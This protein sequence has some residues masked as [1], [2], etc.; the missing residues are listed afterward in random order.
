MNIFDS[1]K[2]VGG[3][4]VERVVDPE[5][6]LAMFGEERP[7][8]LPGQRR[9]TARR[10]AHKI[11][12]AFTF[13]FVGLSNLMRDSGF[14]SCSKKR[15]EIGRLVLTVLEGVHDLLVS[16]VGEGKTLQIVDNAGW[17]NFDAVGMLDAAEQELLEQ[18]MGTMIDSISSSLESI[19]LP[20]CA[21]QE[22]LAPLWWNAISLK[23]LLNSLRHVGAL[24]NDAEDEVINDIFDDDDDLDDLSDDDIADD[25]ACLDE[26]DNLGKEQGATRDAVAAVVPDEVAAESALEVLFLSAEEIKQRFSAILSRNRSIARSI[27]DGRYELVKI[28]HFCQS[29]R[30]LIGELDAKHD[31][32]SMV[33]MSL[34]QDVV[35]FKAATRRQIERQGADIK[36]STRRALESLE[37]QLDFVRHI[38]GYFDP[39]S[40]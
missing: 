18:E 15:D 5:V 14:L 33:L 21:S 8:V 37:F 22:E 28:L 11:K 26:L 17:S 3:S 25:L 39:F 19:E 16:A 27:E 24:E 9:N 12:E 2:E 20:I 35:D 7:P 13:P 29:I 38:L 32:D 30:S 36:P 4:P 40:T 1:D 31:L 10:P 23:K 6:Q 34:M